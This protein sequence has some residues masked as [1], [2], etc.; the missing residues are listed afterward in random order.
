MLSA[1]G[2]S[3]RLPFLSGLLV[4]ALAGTV[5]GA[6]PPL[7]VRPADWRDQT[8]LASGWEYVRGD[9]GGIWITLRSDDRALSLPVWTPV[10]L[11]H[12]VN[13][14]DAVDPDVPY[15]Q[16]PAWYRTQLDIA[17]PHAGGRT[18]LHFEGSGQK[19]EVWIGDQRVAERVGGYDEFTVDITD[20]VTAWRA[21]ALAPEL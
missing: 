10:T 14:F 21:S 13:A 6:T 4:L 11:P 16:G 9:V 20:A 3:I 5:R 8:T 18:L 12:C 19:T 7:A 17:N 15:Y 1:V 2:F